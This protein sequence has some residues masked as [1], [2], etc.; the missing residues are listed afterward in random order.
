MISLSLSLSLSLCVSVCLFL[1]LPFREVN[2][3]ISFSPYT[4]HT[5]RYFRFRSTEEARAPFTRSRNRTARFIYA[6]TRVEKPC[7]RVCLCDFADK[8]EGTSECRAGEGE[9]CN[10]RGVH[11][12][13]AC[14]SYRYRAAF[15]RLSLGETPPRAVVVVRPSA[16]VMVA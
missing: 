8:G 9:K 13:I 12:R 15:Y 2:L 10:Q 4:R 3:E 5:L 14:P 7:V 11:T 6:R 1:R 16:S